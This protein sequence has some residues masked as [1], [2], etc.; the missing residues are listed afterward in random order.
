MSFS[1]ITEKLGISTEALTFYSDFHHLTEIRLSSTIH[2]NIVD[3]TSFWW[4]N[5]RKQ[6]DLSPCSLCLY[7]HIFSRILTHMDLT[8]AIL[9]HMDLTHYHFSPYGFN[10]QPS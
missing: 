8:I 4:G 9:V 3:K 10:T 6:Q 1:K 7:L 5:D 2:N